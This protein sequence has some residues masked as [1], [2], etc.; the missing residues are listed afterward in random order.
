M[1]PQML[2]D[3][4]YIKDYESA[5]DEIF[6]SGMEEEDYEVRALRVP[7][8]HVDAIWLHKETGANADLYIPVRTMGFFEKN[9]IYDKKT[10]F[11]ILKEAA[12]DYDLSDDRLGG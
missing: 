6:A 3:H 2:K 10:F 8:I 7:A 5:L 12:K 9:M 1:E 4:D 11:D